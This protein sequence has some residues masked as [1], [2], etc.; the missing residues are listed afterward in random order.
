MK[1]LC[2]LA[3]LPFF[4]AC[5]SSTTVTKTPTGNIKSTKISSRAGAKKIEKIIDHA[6]A[7]E[8]TRYK[9]GGTTRKGMDCS[10]LVFTAFE[11]E[12]VQLPRISRDMAKRGK[13]I[14][15]NRV[16]EGDLVFFQT[17]K[18][19]KVINHVGLV[20][21]TKSGDVQFIHSTTS[22]GVIVSSLQERYWKS[23]F[24]EVRR[25]I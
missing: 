5:G 20:V 9:Y 25:I 1:K 19:R 13:R 11:S 23:A 24:V 10:G 2:L 16:D 8:G 22:R 3:F 6:L 21:S 14:P 18:N 4:I 12:R 7:F 15:I 17:N